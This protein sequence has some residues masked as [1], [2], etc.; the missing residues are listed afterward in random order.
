MAI[1]YRVRASSH[2]EAN[3]VPRALA[4]WDKGDVPWVVERRVFRLFWVS[5]P[6]I[7]RNEDAAMD[8]VR[9]QFVPVP[10]WRYH[11]DAKGVRVT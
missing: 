8:Y 6:V 9:R 2:W 11:C 5:E 4:G 7:F 10:Q 3:Q 1:K